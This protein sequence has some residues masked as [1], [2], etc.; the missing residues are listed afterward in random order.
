M[1]R[2]NINRFNSLMDYLLSHQY[3]TITEFYKIAT[4]QGYNNQDMPL[5]LQ[6]LLTS[7]Y[8][9]QYDEKLFIKR[10]YINRYPLLGHS[11]KSIN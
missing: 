10:R 6:H 5:I 4:A 9:V 8:L 1:L 2:E 11:D 3:V 7:K